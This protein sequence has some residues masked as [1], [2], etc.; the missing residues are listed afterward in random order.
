MSHFTGKGWNLD[1]KNWVM[2]LK[3]EEILIERKTGNRTKTSKLKRAMIE[4]GISYI[5][6][7]CKIL[8]IWN[9]NPLTLEIDHIDN[10]WL[11]D[12]KENLRFLCPNCHS[13]T[14]GFRN[15]KRII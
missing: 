14:K 3:P 9:N 1:N 7:Q 6:S 2:K 10:N 4:S 12:R 13:Q 11:D 15:K 5:C 8:P